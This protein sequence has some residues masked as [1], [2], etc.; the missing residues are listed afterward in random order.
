MTD[1]VFEPTDRSRLGRQPIRGAYDEASVFDV[2]DA[3]V[4]AHVSYVIDGQPYV[5]PTAFW[6]E[7]RRLYWHG[8]SGSRMLGELSK[9]AEACVAVSL[10]DGLVLA[11]SGF[12]HSINYRSVMAFGRARLI[13]DPEEKRAALDRFID[14]LYPGRAATLRPASA[15]ELAKTSI[16][17]MTIEEA[18]AKVRD[19]GVKH[20]VEDEGWPAW[21]GVLP[22]EMHVG[23]PVPDLAVGAKALNL[24]ASPP[25]PAGARL[26]LALAEAAVAALTPA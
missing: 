23:V 26:D 14:R 10:L 21:A 1:A 11:P 16:V 2:L 7:G 13:A 3:A 22:V 4:L 12:A 5:T 17:G 15:E 20:M 18:A 9:G 8:S 6:R 19:G 25:I 24:R